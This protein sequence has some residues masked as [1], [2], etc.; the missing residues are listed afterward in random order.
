M[1]QL[2]ESKG[3]YGRFW[4]MLMGAMPA[5]ILMSALDMGVFELLDEFRS[6]AEV[7]QRL[8]TH[9]EN[10]RRFLDSLV[11]VDLLEKRNDLYRSLPDTRDFLMRGTPLY[12][13]DLLRFSQGI[14]VD[15]LKDL[16]KLLREGPA[17]GPGIDDENRGANGVGLCIMELNNATMQSLTL[18]FFR[19]IRSPAVFQ[20]FTSAAE[21]EYLL[22]VARSLPDLGMNLLRERQ[23]GPYFRKF[24][25]NRSTIRSQISKNLSSI[26]RSLATIP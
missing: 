1:K 3:S 11:T 23:I 9:P 17:P 19:L 15:P 21:Y 12:L 26:C 7:A 24:S 16:P 10:T 2:P 13:G 5:E 14:C 18:A 22:V 25:T 6:A 20:S 4:R 8:D